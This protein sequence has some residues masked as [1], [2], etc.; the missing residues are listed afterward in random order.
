MKRNLVYA[1][2]IGGTASVIG[3]TSAGLAA[4]D[5]QPKG[6]GNGPGQGYSRQLEVKA[7]VLNMTTDQLR[8][9][10]KTKT[11][12]QIA[13][14]QNVSLETLQ[15]KLAEQAQQRWQAAGLS[16]EEIQQRTKAM[17]DR[18]ANCDGDG[19]AGVWGQHGPQRTSSD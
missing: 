12:A 17:E 6:Q 15:A 8:A 7:Q 3:L 16:A 4:A 1:A 18:H 2:V 14:E 19:H 13:A 5:N 9:Q 11:L 10:L